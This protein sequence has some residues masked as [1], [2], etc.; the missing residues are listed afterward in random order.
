MTVVISAAAALAAAIAAAVL[1]VQVGPGWAVGLGI[2]AA[3]PVVVLLVGRYRTLDAAAR[4]AAAQRDDSERFSRALMEHGADLIAVLNADGSIRFASPSHAHV[5]G[6]APEE[7]VGRNAF[8][9]IHPDDLPAVLK[10]F[11]GTLDAS[12]PAVLREFRFRHR[13]GSWRTIEAAARSALNDPAIAGAVINSRDVTERRRAEDA[14]REETAVAAAL[15]RIGREL[16][17][18]LDRPALLERLCRLTVEELGCEIS[19]T[20]LL[21][22]AQ[23]EYVPVASFGDP[24]EQWEALRVVRIPAAQVEVYVDRLRAT[25]VAE[26]NTQALIDGEATLSTAWGRLRLLAMALRRGGVLVGVHV[27]RYGD[28]H[29]PCTPLQERIARG[30][31]QLASLALE[32]ARLVDELDRAN[33]VKSDFVASMSHELRTPLNVIIG[34]SDLL[35]DQMFGELSAEQEE[36]VRRVGEQGRELLELV[37]TTL[38]MSRVESGRIALAMTEVDLVELLAEI[39]LEAQL[40]RRNAA[41]EVSWHVAPDVPALWTDPMK[42]KVVIK[43]LLLNAIK[44]TDEGGVV[45]R[46]TASDGGVEIDVSDSGIGIAPQMLARIFEPFRQGD[47]GGE[48]RGGVGLGL[49]IVRRLL[50]M[51]GGRIEVESTLHRGSTFRVW[52]PVRAEERCERD[53]PE[54]PRASRAVD[55]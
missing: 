17:S 35:V 1:A 49:H 26:M 37:N 38:D 6:Y 25:D 42:L 52:L 53:V 48:R 18:E 3:V 44:F 39:E 9:F 2:M 36:T 34:Y 21:D 4:R 43:N 29:K 31:A 33:R 14:L 28:R 11:A 5:L 51:L 22:T 19:R 8:D 45:V 12:S 41:L 55:S 27:A 32:N 47:H 7:L 54:M 24:P 13:D 40:V 46:A 50:D 15:A 20:Y 23:G 16:I 30:V 10:A